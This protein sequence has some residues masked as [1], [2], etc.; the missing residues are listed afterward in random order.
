MAR[1]ISVSLIDTLSH[2]ASC[3]PAAKR[4][5]RW[6]RCCREVMRLK[7]CLLTF[8]V[9]AVLGSGSVAGTTYAQSATESPSVIAAV[10][11]ATYPAIARQANARGEVVIEVQVDAEGNVLSAKLISG[12]PLLQKVSEEAAKQWKFSSLQGSTKEQAVRLT[13]AYQTVEKGPN[14][15]NEFTTIFRPP[16]K[17]EVQAH[18]RII[19]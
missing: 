10:A 11:P 4:S 2:D 9:I 19:N 1:G 14:P 3:Q 5:V 17:V 7:H 16:Y 18:P 6:F 12:H 8:V 15:K 13:F